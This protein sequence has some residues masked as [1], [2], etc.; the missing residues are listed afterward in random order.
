MH[1]ESCKCGEPNGQCPHYGW[2]KGRKWEVCQGIRVT[3]D[4]RDRI[5]DAYAG[6]SKY[7][8]PTILQKVGS[9]AKAVVRHAADAGAKTEADILGIRLEI[10]GKCPEQKEDGSCG[11][12]G[13]LV[14]LKASWRS[15]ACPLLKWPGDLEASEKCGCKQERSS[16]NATPAQ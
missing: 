8:E 12:C 4:D 6:L 15:E 16:S 2:M 7:E 9:F 14:S 3:P 5:L 13:C 10:C 11:V 1:H